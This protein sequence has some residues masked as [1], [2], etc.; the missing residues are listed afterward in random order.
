[1][2]ETSEFHPSSYSQVHTILHADINDAN[3][4]FEQILGHNATPEVKM[5]L[6]SAKMQMD[7]VSSRR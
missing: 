4:D 5:Q 1:M 3:S 7:S 2:T 6:A